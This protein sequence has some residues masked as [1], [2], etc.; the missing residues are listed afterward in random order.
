MASRAVAIAVA[1]LVVTSSNAYEWQ[2]HNGMA[3]NARQLLLERWVIDEGL[4]KFINDVKLRGYGEDLDTRAGDKDQGAFTDEDHC[5][6]RLWGLVWCLYQEAPCFALPEDLPKKWRD[7]VNIAACTRD[8]FS[9]KLPLLLLQEDARDH[10]QECLDMAVTG[11][12]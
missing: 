9:P 12:A 1:L 3:K 7:T 2:T 5:E 4:R 6:G 11:M 8:H 10:A